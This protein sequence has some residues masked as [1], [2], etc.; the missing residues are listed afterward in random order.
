V[1]TLEVSVT[2]VATGMVVVEVTVAVVNAFS[3]IVSD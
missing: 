2:V 3:E 1:V